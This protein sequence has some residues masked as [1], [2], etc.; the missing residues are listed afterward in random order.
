MASGTL[1]DEKQGIAQDGIT[2][3]G[4]MT[5]PTA[6]ATLLVDR[7]EPGKG[8]ELVSR[9]EIVNIADAG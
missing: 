4:D 2:V 1:P 9:Q 6:I 5:D 3:F 7:I 8:P